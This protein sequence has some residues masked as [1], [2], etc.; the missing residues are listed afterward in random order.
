VVGCARLSLTR[1]G[2][3][4]KTRPHEILARVAATVES[5]DPVAQRP[6]PPASRIPGRGCAVRPGWPILDGE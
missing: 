5:A 4:P 6:D 3:A 2:V 1:P